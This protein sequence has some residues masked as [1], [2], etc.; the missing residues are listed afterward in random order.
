M[1]QTSPQLATV[2]DNCFFINSASLFESCLLLTCFMK[3]QS[4]RIMLVLIQRQLSPEPSNTSLS[5]TR[6]V[7]LTE[8]PLSLHGAHLLSLQTMHSTTGECQ[9][10]W[11]EGREVLWPSWT[12]FLSP[13]CLCIPIRTHLL[14]EASPGW[15]WA[16]LDGPVPFSGH[17]IYFQLV[18]LSLTFTTLASTVLLTALWKRLPT[19]KSKY[20]IVLF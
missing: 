7:L 14:P 12:P 13:L 19:L 2:S 20:P 9:C 10:P 1:G 17:K 6:N 11:Q 4:H 5:S 3:I 15:L 16:F 8:M 18:L